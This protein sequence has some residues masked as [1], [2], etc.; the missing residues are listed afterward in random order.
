MTKLPSDVLGQ[1][2]DIGRLVA[3]AGENASGGA[4]GLFASKDNQ[5]AYKVAGKLIDDAKK[6]VA[7]LDAQDH[8]ALSA[9]LSPKGGNQL[10]QKLSNTHHVSSDQ[11][12]ED[13]PEET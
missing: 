6:E 11:V 12:D 4:S 5:Q 7:S 9:N 8:L 3:Q 10:G 13:T 1:L 2:D